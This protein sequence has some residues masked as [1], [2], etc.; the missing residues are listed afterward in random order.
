MEHFPYTKMPVVHFSRINRS[1]QVPTFRTWKTVAFYPHLIH[2]KPVSAF[3]IVIIL[4]CVMLSTEVATNSI[5]LPM[6]VH[7]VERFWN[8]TIRAQFEYIP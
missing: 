1:F 3:H 5:N 4:K 7:A 8:H 2:F 6:F